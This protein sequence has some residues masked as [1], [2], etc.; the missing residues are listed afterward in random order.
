MPRAV[1]LD[2]G[3]HAV[4]AAE[5]RLGRP[6]QLI[7]FGQVGLARGAVE[8][9]EVVDPATVAAALRRLWRDA[10]LRDRRVRVGLAGL[11]TIVR[12]VEIPAMDEEE[13]RSALEFQAGEFIPLPAQ[14]TLL[15]FR[16]VE[17]FESPEGEAMTRVL[18]AAV[19]RDALQNA[20]TAVREAGLQAVAFDLAPFALLRS[21]V[22]VP[23]QINEG[24]AGPNLEAE[25]IVSVGSGVT[26]VVVHESGV[27]RFVRIVDAGG[28]DFTLAIEQALGI[29]F[30][31]AEALK[32]QLGAAVDRGDEA[33]TGVEAP[34]VS[35]V[36]EI[37][38]SVD[39]YTS[40]AGARRVGRVVLTG[41]GVLLDGFSERVA[42]ALGVPAD[43]GDAS[44]GLTMGD[45]GF[46]PDQLPALQAYLPVAVGLALGADRLA[47]YRMNLLP[48]REQRVFSP[49]RLVVAGA[50]A[51]A[52]VAGGLAV[53]T[54]QRNDDLASA[55]DRLEQQQSTNQQL[56]ETIA[57][58]RGAR[59]L[60]AEADQAQATLAA[61]LQGEVSW[62]R[63]LQEVARVIPGDVWLD[64]LQATSTPSGGGEA[65]AGSPAP[66]AA[67]G[68]GTLT[69]TARGTDFPAA[70]AWLQRLS[71][72][73]SIELPWLGQI[74]QTDVTIGG[75]DF[76]GITFTSN[77]NLTAAATTARARRAAVQGG[78]SVTT[79]PTTP[80]PQGA[81]P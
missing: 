80:P 68:G 29:S 27:V 5:L 17:S 41:G 16:V 32:R 13:L 52:L 45:V 10:H 30:D 22:P 31:E 72:L 26:I 79:A 39:F 59:D 12:Q 56:Q 76:P 37:R 49:G 61:V 18:I 24:E 42:D 70:A 60:Q 67:A 9:G 38:G 73:P 81:A 77:A 11:R 33:L 14:D 65:V 40:Q 28:D 75:L 58:L 78:A 36:N 62:S 6:S 43:F 4:R 1:G 46:L 66:A 63:L 57:G 53:L 15:D 71:T 2:I 23:A 69:F 21:L 25:V 74:S 50:A 48:E 19:H 51:A 35:L 8:H 34:V 7:G 54:M 20:L 47:P 64:S 44:L 3:S 55:R